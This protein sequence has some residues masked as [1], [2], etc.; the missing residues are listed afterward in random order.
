M[1]IMKPTSIGLY[2]ALLE[3]ACASSVFAADQVTPPAYPWLW[4]RE[5]QWPAFAW[6]FPLLCFVMMMVMLLFMIRTGGMGCMRRGRP[7]DKSAFRDPVS[8]SRSEPA[9]SA[10]EILNQRYVRGEIDKRE[11]E[12]KKAAITSSR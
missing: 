1:D 2:L 8:P 9:A 3:L 4:W 6:I 10:L 12:D 5:T 7:S 11:Y